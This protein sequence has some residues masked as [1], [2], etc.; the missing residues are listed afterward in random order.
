MKG[1]HC[2]NA[3]VKVCRDCI[4][5]HSIQTTTG[6]RLSMPQAASV[7]LSL[8]VAIRTLRR[9]KETPDLIRLGWGRGRREDVCAVGRRRFCLARPHRDGRAKKKYHLCQG[10]HRRRFCPQHRD[11]SSLV[12]YFHSA[13][14]CK[15]W[16]FLRTRT[17]TRGAPSV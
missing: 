12:L 5:S 8:T 17:A 7:R 6:G 10:P 9:N 11:F 13:R 4:G 15:T 2:G 3:S 14:Y 1:S 16:Y